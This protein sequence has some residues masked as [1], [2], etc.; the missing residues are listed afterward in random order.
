MSDDKKGSEE[1]QKKQEAES[2]KEPTP[3]TYSEEEFK[4]VVA[5]R[6]AVKE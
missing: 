2:V 1:Q 4:K 6:Q 5:E 3:K